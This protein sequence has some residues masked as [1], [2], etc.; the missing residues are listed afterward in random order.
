MN[1]KMLGKLGVSLASLI[2]IGVLMNA[3]ASRA[4]ALVQV[5]TYSGLIS[6]GLDLERFFPDASI[7]LTFQPFSAVFTY[8]G[9]GLDQSA[10]LTVA[11]DIFNFPLDHYVEHDVRITPSY[12]FS[13]F[14]YVVGRYQGENVSFEVAAGA[15]VYDITPSDYHATNLSSYGG[16]RVGTDNIFLFVT[17]ASI[18]RPL[19]PEPSTWAIIVLG[20]AGAGI[21]LRRRRRYARDRE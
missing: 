19:L 4:S 12:G 18:N 13:I 17:D 16:L 2:G 8:D 11:G 1:L 10:T 21:A 6:G 20:F 7:D 15:L 5:V 14:D 3:S 9:S